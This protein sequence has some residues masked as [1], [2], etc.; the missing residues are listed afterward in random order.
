M[1]QRRV[2]AL[3][4]AGL[5]L[6]AGCGGSSGGSQSDQSSGA[7]GSGDK[8]TIGAALP[9]LQGSFWISMSYGIVDE[10]EKQGVELVSLNAGGY[11]QIQKQVQ[12]IENLVQKK[13]D[14][15][16]V[17]A[18]NGPGVKNAVEN[19]IKAGIPVIGISSL[20]EPKDKLLSAIGADHYTMGALQAQCLAKEMG[21]QGEVAVM[22]GPPGVSWAVERVQGFKE[23][24]AKEAPGI[25][26]VAEKATATGRAEG[27]KLMEDWLQ[28]NPNVGGVYSAVDDLGAGAVDALKS[29]NKAGKVKVSSS[30]LSPIGE[31]YLRQG[32]LQCESIQQIVLQGR[33]A[34][35]QAVNHKTG[36]EVTKFVKTP[37]LLITKENIDTQDYTDIKAPKDY[38]PR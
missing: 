3:S 18:T 32:L 16:L 24:L 33:E 20:P 2:L 35:R 1:K 9:E 17:G 7:G 21:G 15:L 12:Q 14:V 28:A 36:K 31:E 27:L 29:A 23:A 6:L 10:A 37:V 26:I 5:L 8:I 13:V 4:L 34:I 22:A 25:K 11:D 38:K 30:N 19:A